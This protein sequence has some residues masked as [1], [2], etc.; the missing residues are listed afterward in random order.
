MKK[1]K[2]LLLAFVSLITSTT[3]NAG[4][5]VVE[6][7]E[8]HPI[9]TK[10][11]IVE[12][13]RPSQTSSTTTAE[14]IEDPTNPGNK[15]LCLTKT[16]GNDWDYGFVIELPTQL[17][18][19][20]LTDTFQTL[21]MKYYRVS[22]DKYPNFFV[23][24]GGTQIGTGQCRIDG[25]ENEWKSSS[26]AISN[27][28]D[29]STTSLC[30]C[31]RH[32]NM[33]FYVDDIVLEGTGSLEEAPAITTDLNAEYTVQQTGAL[34]LSVAASGSPAPSY[35]WYSNN[36]A[37]TDGASTIDGATSA[38]YD[39]ATN[40]LGIAYY[41]C[42]AT[43]DLGSA[44]SNIAKVTVI[45]PIHVTG[46]TLDQTTLNIN[47]GQSATLTATVLPN[48][49][50]N[51]NVTWSTN[52]SSVA[53]V[54][55]GV[56]TGVAEGE[57]TITATTVDGGFTATCTVT[58]NASNSKNGQYIAGGLFYMLEDF[59][60]MAIDDA[61][62]VENAGSGYAK[63]V[64]DPNGAST[65][66]MEFVTRSGGNCGYIKITLPNNI[67]YSDFSAIL[68][69]YCSDNNLGGDN[70]YKTL[71]VKV[72]GTSIGTIATQ[73]PSTA[74]KTVKF[75]LAGNISGNEI[76]LAIGDVYTNGAAYIFDNI[77]LMVDGSFTQVG[78]SNTWWKY[79]SSTGDFAIKGE[80]A[81]PDHNS[82]SSLPWHSYR[83]S[84][85][86]NVVI[87]EGITSI[88]KNAFYECKAIT[89]VSFPS[90][91]ESIGDQ[92]FKTNTELLEINLENTKVKTI[93]TSAFEGCNKVA[94]V[95][96]P[97]T[98]E[99]IAQ[100]GLRIN[101]TNNVINFHSN[102]TLGSSALYAGK[103]KE[104]NLILNDA[105][106]PFVSATT[107]NAYTSVEYKRSFS[108][109][110]VTLMLPFVP[111][112]LEGIKL[113]VLSSANDDAITF[114]ETDQ[115]VANTPYLVKATEAGM[116]NIAAGQ[117]TIAAPTAGTTSVGDWT[118]EGTYTTV[119]KTAADNAYGFSQ[120]ALFKNTG[121]MKIN[122][123]R[124]FVTTSNPAAKAKMN[125][126]FGGEATAINAADAMA[127][128]AE[129]F[130]ANGA[131]QA[132]LQ[133]GINIVKMSDGKVRKVIIK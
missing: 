46:V 81:I 9:G 23:N 27:A 107:S 83:D 40:D 133:K 130:N 42:V 115:F 77:R 121:N 52:N 4:S 62:V 96:L 63:V 3:A 68:F 58:V 72:N 103:Y 74:W 67:N 95:A 39:V 55:N 33:Q 106:K 110:Y 116:K 113:Y 7:F 54:A 1:L 26:Y 32:N 34:K 117:T 89:S 87:G 69:D 92:A 6:D 97:A 38:S 20:K 35:Q 8:S 111:E 17:A 85:I 93:G 53:T 125:L 10:F 88:G 65:N 15:V 127:T 41:Y 123:F 43:N 12:K 31:I 51:Q 90:T 2:L 56:V 109:N 29:N 112:D 64:A 24:Y 99:E 57:A 60:T 11:K 37:S 101:N 131:R 70:R 124:A 28:P 132:S 21:K 44:T 5:Y 94:K 13:S 118:M 16:G 47:R 75:D 19:K 128:I 50:A 22:G 78:T 18:G 102:P 105:E 59:E 49:A 30:L 61:G 73:E 76:V 66:A 80:G 82:S 119:T 129:I 108:T 71:Q 120:G 122:P 79:D 36:T 104:L 45:E 84:G 100:N 86:K 48:D 114:T 91:L 25:N 126:D 14:V 98:L